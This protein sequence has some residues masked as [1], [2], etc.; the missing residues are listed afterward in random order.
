MIS[1]LNDPAGITW[2]L[3]LT[4][5]F[6]NAKT[7]QIILSTILQIILSIILNKKYYEPSLE[8]FCQQEPNQE[9]FNSVRKIFTAAVLYWPV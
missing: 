3:R 2:N 8:P 9:L 5:I 1:L 4:K 6:F 7:I